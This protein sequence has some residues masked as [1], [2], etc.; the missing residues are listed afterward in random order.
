MSTFQWFLVF[1]AAAHLLCAACIYFK[2]GSRKWILTA[3]VFGLIGVFLCYIS[4][5]VEPDEEDDR[6]LRLPPL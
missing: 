3:L 6:N 4:G 1:T 5:G 2:G